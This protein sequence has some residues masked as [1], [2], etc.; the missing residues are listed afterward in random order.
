[1]DS[2]PWSIPPTGPEVRQIFTLPT[3]LFSE[4]NVF[5]GPDPNKARGCWLW[6][7]RL[8]CGPQSQHRQPAPVWPH[9]WSAHWEYKWSQH[10]ALWQY[11]WGEPDQWPRGGQGGSPVQHAHDTTG[12][13]QHPVSRPV[14]LWRIKSTIEIIAKLFSSMFYMLEIC[15]IVNKST[16]DAQKMGIQVQNGSKVKILLDYSYVWFDIVLAVIW[17]IVTTLSI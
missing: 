3:I 8:L 10:A 13:S 16:E 6:H 5:L 7:E 11:K 17:T 14:K 2:W 9:L 1:M 4:H 12:G 15:R